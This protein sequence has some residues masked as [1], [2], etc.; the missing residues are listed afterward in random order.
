MGCLLLL[1]DCISHVC[2]VIVCGIAIC[3]NHLP[4]QKIIPGCN[5]QIYFIHITW[6]KSEIDA[7]DVYK[8]ET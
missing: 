8:W 3:Y 5:L 4:E 2:R 6:E 7:V 1:V